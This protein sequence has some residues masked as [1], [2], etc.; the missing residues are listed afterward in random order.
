MSKKLSK[1]L[2]A[3]TSDQAVFLLDIVILAWAWPLALILAG[4]TSSGCIPEWLAMLLYPA[5]NLVFLYALGLYRRDVI[6]E[7]RKS[8]GRVPLAAGLAALAAAG[9]T[10]LSCRAL[11]PMHDQVRLFTAA[12]TCF[13]VSGLSR[14][15]WYSLR[16]GTTVCSA[17][18]S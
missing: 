7:P 2:S 5:A 8:V 9:V 3:L 11:G 14:P 13:L 6:M 16:C 12:V 10:T 15:A 1:T 18:A 4:V 17:T